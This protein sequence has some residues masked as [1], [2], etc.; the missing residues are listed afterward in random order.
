MTTPAWLSPARLTRFGAVVSLGLAV[1]FVVVVATADGV[2]TISS[3]RLG[4]DWAAFWSAGVLARTDPALLLDVGAQRAVMSDVLRGDFAP[5]PY[6]PLFAFLF[7]PFALF[8]FSTGY[9]LYV[10]VLV[11]VGIVAVRWTMDLVGTSPRWRPVGMLGAMTYAGTFASWGGAQNAT[12]TLL[13]L[14]GT[15]RLL[16]RGRAVAAGLVLASL[17]FKPQYALPVIG[18]VLVAGHARTAVVALAGGVVLWVAHV[19][20]FGSDWTVAWVREILRATDA[21]NRTFNTALTVSPVEWIRGVLAAP[22]GDVVGLAVAVVIG[23]GFAWLAHR[24]R[25]PAQWL[26]LTGVALL[27]TAPHALRY[28]LALLVPVL[29]LLARRRD[30]GVLLAAWVIG[31]VLLLDLGPALRIAYV[32][33]IAGMLVV[34]LRR[35]DGDH[36]PGA[37]G[38]AAPQPADP[39]RG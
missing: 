1:A 27:L 17:W 15:A 14:A 30:P 2:D 13:V 26:A 25:D 20:V 29:A 37:V 22:W 34:D 3:G 6:P 18:L 8:S 24:Y 19:P 32:V 10:L 16:D 23:A 7:V 31:P 4:G 36:G 5:F 39:L 35:T 21:G 12:I 9:V 33:V 11:V 28:E 38:P